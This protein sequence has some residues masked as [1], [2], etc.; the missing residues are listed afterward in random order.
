MFYRWLASFL[1][2]STSLRTALGQQYEG[3]FEANSLPPVAGA[4]IEFFRI[5][6]SA[7]QN[8]TLIVRL[9]LIAPDASRTFF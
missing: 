8:A 9:S 1:L 2:L 5:K 6:D 4:S 3:D 7:G